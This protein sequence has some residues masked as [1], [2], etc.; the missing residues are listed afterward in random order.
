M[1]YDIF[2]GDADGIFSLHQ[3]RLESPLPKARLITG[4]KRDIWLLSRLE[5]VTDSALTV[6]DISFDSNR[7]SLLKILENNN[8]VVYF[9]HH[10]A[11]EGIDTRALQAHLDP[12]PRTCTS[13]LVNAAL[14]GS[15]GLWAI[16]GAFGDNLLEPALALGQAL[17]LSDKQLD[18][19]REL[20]ELFNYNGYGESL[21]DLH[22]HPQK[23]Y[24][25]VQP[26]VNPFDFY[27]N[28]QLLA[29]LQTGYQTDLAQAMNQKEMK[30][31]GNNR[32]Y[33]L[34]NEPWARRVAGVFSN[35]RARE[36]RSAAHVVITEN[37]DQTL[38]ISVRAPLAEQGHADTLCKLFP[39]GGGR[40]AA[41]GINSLPAEM[42][43]GFLDTFQSF[44]S[45]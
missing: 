3:Y 23:L 10:F 25:A 33:L 31:S 40:A 36:K 11:G 44:Y 39:T 21:D 8:R 41:A 22:F 34:P 28:S 43:G 12:S 27:Q 1:D 6:F 16:C 32:V 4:V 15:H 30:T 26:Y 9:D 18:R 14:G 17:H 42:L 5:N 29:T 37:H 13:L 7:A 20:G 38:R 2:N 24:E 19:L 45:R 35:F